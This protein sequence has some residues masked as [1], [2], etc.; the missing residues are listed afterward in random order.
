MGRQASVYLEEEQ[1]E[2][3]Q[4]LVEEDRRYSSFSHVVRLAIDQF[5]GRA[6]EQIR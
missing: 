4:E 1:I 6:K 5:L 3:V 2:E